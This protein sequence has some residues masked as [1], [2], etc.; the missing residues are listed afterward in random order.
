M[1]K[2][3]VFLLTT[4]DNPYNPFTQWLKWYYE[5]QALGYDT[6]GLLA[7]MAV[8]STDLNDEAIESAMFDVVKN[9]FSGKHIMVTED[10]V[11]FKQNA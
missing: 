5:D 1:R 2:K 10:D 6:P 11:F 7:R 3:P 4:I 8:S 9:N